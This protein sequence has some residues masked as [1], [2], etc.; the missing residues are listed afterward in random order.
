MDKKQ[1]NYEVGY[2]KPPSRR[3]FRRV[4]R[5][6]Q[7]GVRTARETRV[8]C[9]EKYCRKGW[10]CA[11]RTRQNRHKEGTDF[12]VCG[13]QSSRQVTLKLAS[14]S[15]TELHGCRRSSLNRRNRTCPTLKPSKK[16]KRYCAALFRSRGPSE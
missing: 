10:K 6:I 4:G 9:S 15:S 12:E 11:K 7:K 13:K 3:D 2:G 8:P 5:E 14:S 16:P 1:G